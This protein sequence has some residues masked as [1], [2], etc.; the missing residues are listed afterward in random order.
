MNKY[1]CVFFI[2]LI[3]I[4]IIPLI[5]NFYDGR[6]EHK[7]CLNCFRVVHLVKEHIPTLKPSTIQKL[8]FLCRTKATIFDP[9]KNM[10]NVKGSKMNLEQIRKYIPEIEGRI[11][12]PEL[13]MYIRNVLNMNVNYATYPPEHYRLFVRLYENDGDFI[14]WHYDNNFTKGERYTLVIPLFVDKCNTS[15]LMIKDRKTSIEKKINIPFG[16]AIIFNASTVFHKVS[17]QTNGCKRLVAIIP[18]YEDYNL[19]YFGK[20][21]K[22]IRDITFNILSL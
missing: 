6:F 5:H 14:N 8:L 17:H 1:I 19:S 22:N 12:S 2:V 20:S 4:I 9:S 3:L 7:L 15:K 13:L 16:K 18:L 10:N 21:R 11:L